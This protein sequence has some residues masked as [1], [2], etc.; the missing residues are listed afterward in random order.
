MK[1]KILLI[2]HDAA[3]TGAPIMFL[4]FV[5]WIKTKHADY[6]ISIIIDKDGPLLE[7]F[8]KYA[9]VYILH[10]NY[11]YKIKR[12][13]NILERQYEAS[14]F[15]K[16][17]SQKWSFIFSNTITN[18]KILEK[19]N[20]SDIPL[21]SYIH[22]LE[23]SIN[24][25]NKRNRVAATLE[26]TD[27]FFCGSEMVK[28]NLIENHKIKPENTEVVYSFKEIKKNIVNKEIRIN[29]KSHYKI[30][31]EAVVVAMLG[32][33]EWRKGNDLFIRTCIENT[34]K[35]IYF[36]WVGIDNTDEYDKINYDLHK[37]QIKPKLI[38]IPSSENYSDFYN[39]IDIFYLSS[40]EDPYPLVMVE[41]S[42]YGIPIICFKGAGGTEEFIKDVGFVA[43]YGD[44]KE[45]NNYLDH[46]EQNRDL[47]NHHKVTM[48]EK[49]NETH[50]I[51]LN[52]KKILEK[53]NKT[54]K[55]GK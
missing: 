18:G 38:L 46:I 41:A 23:N 32:T 4:D 7:E 47:L 13:N 14:I 53:I 49:S 39:I 33:F 27:F 2:S 30:P 11:N 6:E 40:R 43:P 31:H 8:R 34:N 3:R 24:F 45:V 1:K 22:E 15:R 44:T 51:D 29:L 48:I 19:I 35:N 16:I 5:R 50:N 17:N 26:K 20:T 28:F 37:Y 9:F 36:V 10:K 54:V 42:S 12:L 25:Y 55:V 52:A 21:F